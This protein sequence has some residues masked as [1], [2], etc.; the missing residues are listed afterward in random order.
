MPVCFVL[1]SWSAFSQ[2]NQESDLVDI[3][4]K[5]FKWEV[6]VSTDSLR[7]VFHEK[8]LVW[9]TSGEAVNKAAYLQR[10]SSPDFIHNRVT[11]EKSTATIADN[12]AIVNGEGIFDLTISGSKTTL[13]L[14]YTE[15]FTRVSASKPWRL[16]AIDG[17]L[18]E[19]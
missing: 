6:T 11:V 7:E 10:L 1:L 2:R 5:I 13:H 9:G 4:A 19:D 18:K 16:L 12:T 17:K 15:V 14:T 3:S 8:L